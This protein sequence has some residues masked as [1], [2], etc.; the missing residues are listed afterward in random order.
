MT[1][2][3][4][5]KKLHA[6]RAPLIEECIEGG[7]NGATGIKHIVKQDNVAAC[8]IEAD[9]TRDNGGT[10]TCRRQI[11]SVKADVQNPNI[12]RVSLD[13]F[14]HPCQ[15]LRERDS[16]ALDANETEVRAAVILLDDLMRQPHQRS[17]NL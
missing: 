12:N 8:D 17:F 9:R 15:S 14:D 16:A 4:K 10:G 3:N 2:I 7:A 5:N 6:L 11:I 1:T 13:L